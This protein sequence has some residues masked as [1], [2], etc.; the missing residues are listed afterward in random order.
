MHRL[1]VS[2]LIVLAAALPASAQLS[3]DAVDQIVAP[4]RKAFQGLVVG[5]IDAHGRAVY[6]YGVTREGGTT[7][8]GKTLF[9][10]GSVTKLFTSV[11]FADAI[12]SGKVRLNQPVQ[13]L[14]PGSVKMPS[15]DGHTITLE[16][17][18][19][20]MSGLP[21]LPSNLAVTLNNPYA[22]YDDAML[23]E[24]IS[25]LELD[26]APGKFEYSN[27]GMGLLGQLLAR[28][29]GRTYEQLLNDRICQPLG[30]H[31]TVIALDDAHKARLATGHDSSGAEV[32]NWD[33]IALAGC[34]GIRSTG[35]DLL[36]FLAA[37]I[38]LT[39]TPLKDAMQLSHE[40]RGKAD[41]TN[42]IGLGWHI[43]RRN[44]LRWHNGETGGY[45]A[46]VGFW[47]DVKIGV[48]VLCNGAINDTD[49]IG[50]NV[51]RV[52]TGQ[53]PLGPTTTA[54][55]AV[56]I[57]PKFLDAYVGDYS[58]SPTFF[59]RVTRDGEKLFAQATNQANYRIFPDS[60]T[61][62]FYK[63]VDAQITFERDAAGK[64][65]RLWLDQNGQHRAAP[66][67]K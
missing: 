3:R 37:N 19:T 27:F 66:K 13:T 64:T 24:A 6:G 8:D 42:D 60:P 1:I 28:R 58:L 20:H 25:N 43:E 22:D 32:A 10:I 49:T 47:S 33:F 61:H 35:D 57:D 12:E 18:A 34:G 29:A 48:V 23:F 67:I 65:T 11:L 40:K 21:R 9:E 2:A 16:H 31:D 30:M 51:L 36:T 38:G 45:S 4:H 17:L 56:H 59:I 53:K 63:V 26:R 46:F 50:I 44:G 39:E 52:A 5:V 55:A 15:K 54:A 7:P 14:L 62:F 41:K